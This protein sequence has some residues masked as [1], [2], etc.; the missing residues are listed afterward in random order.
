M[1]IKAQHPGRAGWARPG[2]AGWARKSAWA[3]MNDGTPERLT[4]FM[5]LW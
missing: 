2:W 1:P 3:G 5:A 4:D